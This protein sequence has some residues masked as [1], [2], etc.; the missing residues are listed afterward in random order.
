M[1]GAEIVARVLRNR[2]VRLDILR[3]VAIGRASLGRSRITFLLVAALISSG[4]GY[5]AANT[6][7]SRESRPLLKAPSQGPIELY[8]DGAGSRDLARTRRWRQPA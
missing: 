3:A 1:P 4:I 2:R 5:L 8:G 7:G 6:V